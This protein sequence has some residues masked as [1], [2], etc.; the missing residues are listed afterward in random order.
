MQG[1][2]IEVDASEAGTEE[3]LVRAEETQSQQSLSGQSFENFSSLNTEQ[4][5]DANERQM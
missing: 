1:T 2:N 5:R 4:Q 3:I